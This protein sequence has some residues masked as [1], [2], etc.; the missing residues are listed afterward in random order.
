MVLVSSTGSGSFAIAVHGGDAIP[1]RLP[2]FQPDEVARRLTGYLD[3]LTEADDA[4]SLLAKTG[5]DPFTRHAARKR[6]VAARNDLDETVASLLTWLWD[7]A[8][9]PILAELG[10]HDTPG[11]G[12]RVPRL[13]WCPTGPLVLLPFHAAGRHNEPNRSV[14]DRVISSYTPTLRVLAQNLEE[15]PLAHA[16]R[17]L[18]VAMENTPGEADLPWAGREAAFLTGRLGAQAVRCLRDDEALRAVVIRELHEYDAVH[19]CCHSVLNLEDPALG[20][21]VIHD[22]R[23]T[24]ADLI[25]E[26]LGGEFAFLGSCKSATVGPVVLDEVISL[27]SAL[28]HVGFRQV[29]ATLWSVPDDVA[30]RVAELVYS[31]SFDSPGLG[32]RGMAAALRD[33]TRVLR[34]EYPDEPRNWT[35]FLHMGC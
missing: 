27:A 32:L 19:F 16:D 31:P 34:A 11:P 2:G 35:P 1:I 20:G 13:W 28:N 15:E 6:V 29:I 18:I 24:I 30:A 17:L 3:A 10:I 7:S 21:L 4:S 12:E 26:R 25:R 14:L 5:S 8:A 9:E 22:G 33:A 23:L